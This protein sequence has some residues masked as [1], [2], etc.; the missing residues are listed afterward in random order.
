MPPTRMAT[1][2][3]PA[4]TVSGAAAATTRK[5]MAV[6]P[7]AFVLRCSVG[8]G[9]WP[10]EGALELGAPGEVVGDIV[11]AFRGLEGISGWGGEG[12]F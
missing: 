7:S 11:V 5:A 1:G 10:G 2:D 4:I 8:P 3:T 12:I 6:A 9:G